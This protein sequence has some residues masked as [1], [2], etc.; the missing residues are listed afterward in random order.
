MNSFHDQQT[1]ASP[2]RLPRREFL[3]KAAGTALAASSAGALLAACGSDSSSSSS[4]GT[5]TG[6]AA[7]VGGTVT[8]LD[9]EGYRGKGVSDA[10]LAQNGVTI[11]ENLLTANEEVLTKLKAGG[12]GSIDLVSPN[13]AYIP[14]LVAADVLQPIDEERVPNLKQVIPAI[15]ES[16]RESAEIDGQLYAV[17]YMWG[18]DGMVYNAAK[19]SSPPTAW[20]D[21]LDPKYSGK[22]LMISGAFP[23]FEIWPRVLGFET[24]TLTPDQL[25]EVESFLIDLKKE[26]VRVVTG[27]QANMADLLARGDVWLTGSG[28]WVGL[29]SI[30]PE[31]QDELAFTMPPEGGGTTWIDTWAIPKDAPNLDAAYAFLNEMMSAPIQAKQ[32]DTLGMATSNAKATK[33][34]SKENQERYEYDS[35]EIGSELAP[36]FRF[37]EEGKGYT[38]SEEWNEAWNRIQAA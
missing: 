35:G 38:T 29:P 4:S 32:A 26:Q 18:F 3:T 7:S 27:D 8:L 34:V 10:W 14:Q 23:N 5:G 22:V 6:T 1:D 25:A 30:G 12:L 15:S 2:H 13:V 36:L 11:S 20:K 33:I 37:P 19:I 21:V 17:P 24:A 9:W 28:C 16:A 31:G